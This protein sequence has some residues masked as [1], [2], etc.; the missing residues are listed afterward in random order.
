MAHLFTAA[1]DMPCCNIACTRAVRRLLYL[2]V[3][4]ASMALL[5]SHSARRFIK[6]RGC[7]GLI[8]W[9]VRR[10]TCSFLALIML[11]QRVLNYKFGAFACKVTRWQPLKHCTLK[12]N[13]MFMCL[14]IVL[15][16]QCV[17]KN[18]KP[19]SNYSFWSKTG[20]T[21]YI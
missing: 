7:T 8:S 20:K 19:S 1:T 17:S 9:L 21:L 2:S 6:P 12:E 5:L 3:R 16:A 11:A 4:A 14:N 13:T 18:C 15:G 10:I